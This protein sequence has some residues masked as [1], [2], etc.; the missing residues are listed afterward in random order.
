M[1]EVVAV[2]LTML[3]YRCSRQKQNENICIQRSVG[4]NSLQNKS[5]DRL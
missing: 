4:D 5:T 3:G 1:L 2:Q